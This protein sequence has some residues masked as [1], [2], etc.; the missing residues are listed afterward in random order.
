MRRLAVLMLLLL[1][2]PW[3]AEAQRKGAG[4]GGRGGDFGGNPGWGGR[5]QE[6]GPESIGKYGLRRTEVLTIISAGEGLPAL[7][8]YETGMAEAEKG[9]KLGM[10]TRAGAA[11]VLV[12]TRLGLLQKV[13]TVAPHVIALA[14]KAPPSQEVCKGMVNTAV[15]LA[16]AHAA[17][18]EQ[19]K[20]RAVLEAG[21]AFA[22]SPQCA[23]YG[24]AMSGSTASALEVLSSIE[25]AA[26]ERA[27]ALAH[28]LEGVQALE[29]W[30]GLRGQRDPAAA[31]R[32]PRTP[33]CKW[34]A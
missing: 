31:R 16:S 27:A 9:G 10:A 26:G 15:S 18:S 17:V 7:A 24:R 12:A 14:G 2:A 34:L 25:L 6:E 1:L 30:L 20:A 5:S 33:R 29:S 11:A 13:L 28:A 19:A 23:P 4:G 8:A 32:Q 3:P 22:R 21:L